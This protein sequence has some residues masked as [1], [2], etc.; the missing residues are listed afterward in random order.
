M[1]RWW[2]RRL[3]EIPHIEPEEEDDPEWYP[4][5]HHFG[6]SAFGVNVYVAR[7]AGN[8]LLGEHDETSSGHEELYFV[9]A[10]QARFTLDGEERQVA[11]GTVVAV[12]DADVRRAAVALEPGTTIL[13]VGASP[14]VNFE[15]SWN[16]RHFEGVPRAE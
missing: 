3:D 6:L 13:A 7:A 11:A 4:L 15:S 16:P 2:V 1:A 12:P 14:S 5:Q 10:G 8:A 9:T